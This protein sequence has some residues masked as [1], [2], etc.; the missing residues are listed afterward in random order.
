MIIRN[1]HH[2]IFLIAG[3]ISFV[4]VIN[5]HAQSRTKGEIINVNS[6]YKVAFC[7][8]GASVLNAGDIVEVRLKS[9]STLA[10]KVLESTAVLSKLALQ[11]VTDSQS[12]AKLFSQIGVGDMVVKIGRGSSPDLS[13]Y[14]SEVSALTL[15]EIAVSAE[16][17]PIDSDYAKQMQV[18][19]M[20]MEHQNGLL[21]QLQKVNRDAKIELS[22]VYIENEALN[23]ENQK[24][25]QIL[26]KIC[27]KNRRLCRDID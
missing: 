24:N 6:Q 18:F 26:S 13:Q 19:K 22:N 20:Q 21:K 12:D 14:P 8:L 3:I 1:K 4:G 2:F 9:G 23:Q 27:K 16:N 11:Y 17:Q 10:L 7:D 5:T 15:P 25:K